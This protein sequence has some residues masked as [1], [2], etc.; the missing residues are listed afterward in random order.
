MALVDG[1]RSAV[2]E[3]QVQG[4]TVS[5]FVIPQASGGTN[6]AGPIRLE[7]TSRAGYR[8]VAWQEPGLLHAMVG[9]LSPTQLTQLAQ[10]CIRQMGGVVAWVPLIVLTVAT[11]TA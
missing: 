5:Y 10:A 8:L 1:R 7:M 6:P 3:Y 9:D 11:R 4:A 2:I